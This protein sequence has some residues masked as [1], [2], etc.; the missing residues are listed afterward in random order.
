[1]L[2]ASLSTALVVV[3]SYWLES[4]PLQALMTLSELALSF[5]GNRKLLAGVAAMGM[6]F[7]VVVNPCIM[8]QFTNN[9]FFFSFNRNS[10]IHLAIDYQLCRGVPGIVHKNTVTVH[11]Q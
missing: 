3:L 5:A 1:M 7:F 11:R 4:N 2:T 10:D 9:S 6:F 8:P